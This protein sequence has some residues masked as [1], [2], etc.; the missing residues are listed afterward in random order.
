MKREEEPKKH[1]TLTCVSL[2]KEKLKSDLE[3]YEEREFI[4]WLNDIECLWY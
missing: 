4:C 1:L 2:W 3:E